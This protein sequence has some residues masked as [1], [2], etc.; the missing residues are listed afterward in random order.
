VNRVFFPF[1]RRRSS[2]ALLWQFYNLTLWKQLSTEY[3]T[4]RDHSFSFFWKND[5]DIVPNRRWT[6]GWWVSGMIWILPDSVLKFPPAFYSLP[7]GVDE[8]ETVRTM[9][10][11]GFP[12]K[13]RTL[14]WACLPP[15]RLP[16][17]IRSHYWPHPRRASGSLLDSITESWTCRCQTDF[18]TKF[19]HRRLLHWYSICSTSI[20]GF[21][22]MNSSW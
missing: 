11:S 6:H 8:G 16:F 18:W 19:S 17:R 12:M 9:T 1:T 22:S 13:E 4:R 20:L 3:S 15:T 2:S 7:N 10:N 5:T 21:F 14:G